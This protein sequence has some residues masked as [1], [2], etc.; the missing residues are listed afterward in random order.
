MNNVANFFKK[1]VHVYN[2][3]TSEKR[4]ADADCKF[5]TESDPMRR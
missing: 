1:F 5:Y 3:F 4:G 2:L